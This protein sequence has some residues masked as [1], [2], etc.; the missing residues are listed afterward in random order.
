MAKPRIFV[1]STYYDLKYLRKHI[2]TFIKQ[3]GYEAVLFENGDIPFHHD[4]PLDD[5]CYSEI[6]FC[7]ILILIIGGKYGSSTS[8]TPKDLNKAY[9]F[10]N[11]ITKKEYIKA[12]EKGIPIFIFVDKNVHAEYD[13]FKK[14]REN[15]KVNYAHVDSKNIFLLLDEITSQHTNNFVRAFETNDD[16][17][18]WLR[19]Q[20]AGIFCDFLIKNNSDIQLRNLGDQLQ[21][22]KYISETIK[23]YS[24]SIIKITDPNSEVIKEENEKLTKRLIFRFKNEEMIAYLRSRYLEMFG[25]DI[26]VEKMYSAFYS[27][28][29]LDSFL[30]AIK[31]SEFEGREDNIERLFEDYYRLK[32]KYLLL[33]INE[34]KDI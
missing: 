22:L 23:N 24:E 9:E 16:I 21:E 31:M 27:S 28:S 13:T 26:S 12:R 11:S 25:K 3:M 17:T 18:N 8:D 10:F 5:S 19:D 33:H 29:D 4:I 20:W 14:N 7:H 2:E 32:E 34:P 6:E 15:T 30:K 1:S